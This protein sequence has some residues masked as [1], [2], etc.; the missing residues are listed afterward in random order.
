MSESTWFQV[1]VYEFLLLL[2]ERWMYW[3]K[4][5][6][7]VKVILLK[8]MKPLSM[9][10]HLIQRKA[11]TVDAIEMCDKY[12]CIELVQQKRLFTSVY[13]AWIAN[14]SGAKNHQRGNVFAWGPSRWRNPIA[15]RCLSN[16][17][18]VLVFTTA[19]LIECAKSQAIHHTVINVERPRQQGRAWTRITRKATKTAR[20]HIGFTFVLSSTKT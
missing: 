6:M 3:I 10:S 12:T 17:W 19:A 18:S 11:R 4:I 15:D 9:K 7:K 14:W 16:E 1:S 5:G 13:T 8:V 20:L 2:I